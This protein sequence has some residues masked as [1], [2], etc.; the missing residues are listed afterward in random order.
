MVKLSK[1]T[2]FKILHN[3]LGMTKAISATSVP[4]IELNDGNKIPVVSYGTFGR[5]QDVHLIKPAVIQAIEAGYRHID[6]AAIYRNEEQVGEAIADVTN[7]GIV[8]REELWITT[9]INSAIG[10]R[11]GVLPA[12]KESL[13]KL[14]L[15]YIDL[16]LIHFPGNAS[17]HDYLNVW[18]GMEDVQKLNLTRSIGVAN[19]NTQQLDRVIANSDTVPSVNQVEV[20]PFFNNLDIV[21]YSQSLNISVMSYANF[22]FMVPRPWLKQTPYQTFEEPILRQLAQKYGKMPSQITLRYLL[23]RGTIVIPRS[24]NK[25]HIEINIDVFDFKLTQEEIKLIN[26]VDQGDKVYSFDPESLP[27]FLEYFGLI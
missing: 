7:R 20:H 27:A 11:E 19:F 13:Q 22:G 9:K 6:T 8:T 1:T 2:I 4:Y 3:Y 15:D 24:T 26:E 12:I 25:I 16:Y 21:E 5:V 23:E 17:N 10:T 14:N 18:K